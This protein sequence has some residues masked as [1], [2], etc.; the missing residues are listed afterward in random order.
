MCNGS[1]VIH[2]E[3]FCRCQTWCTLVTTCLLVEP[4]IYPLVNIQAIIENDHL[5]L[6]YL[7]KMVISHSYMLV[8]QRVT[9]LIIIINSSYNPSYSSCKQLFS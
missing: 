7:V 2:I 9:V 4:I 8:Y 1:M 6:I 5:W 3:V